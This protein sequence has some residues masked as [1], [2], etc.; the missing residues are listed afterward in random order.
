MAQPA[1]ILINYLGA[2][3]AKKGEIYQAS[4]ITGSD[5]ARIKSRSGAMMSVDGTEAFP[6]DYDDDIYFNSTSKYIFTTDCLI[7][8]GTVAVVP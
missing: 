6:L 2:L 5:I 8:H 4:D 7:A 1:K 3:I